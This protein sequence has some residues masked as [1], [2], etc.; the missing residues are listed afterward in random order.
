MDVQVE[1]SGGRPGAETLYGGKLHL[2][3]F[4]AGG[5]GGHGFGFYW[6]PGRVITEE[7]DL[8]K[9]FDLSKPGTYTVHAL[10]VDP[11]TKQTV[12]SNIIKFTVTQ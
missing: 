2:R 9:E 5:G 4:P 1:D 6:K 10:R 8:N 7:S 3:R 11:D 12:T